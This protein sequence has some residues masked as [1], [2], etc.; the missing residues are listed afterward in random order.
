M[1]IHDFY[2]K[3]ASGG[4]RNMLFRAL[5]RL[6]RLDDPRRIFMLAGDPAPEQSWPIWDSQPAPPPAQ[7]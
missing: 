6:S 3:F 5:R 2:L 7:A 1:S 4:E